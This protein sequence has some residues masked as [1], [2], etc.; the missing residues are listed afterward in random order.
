MTLSTFAWNIVRNSF[1]CWYRLGT[2]SN[3]VIR[4]R[5]RHLPRHGLAGRLEHGAPGLF[6]AAGR[7]REAA[8][9]GS[10]PGWCSS[11]RARWTSAF[12]GESVSVTD[13]LAD[14][15][16]LTGSATLDGLT[17]QGNVGCDQLLRNDVNC[18]DVFTTGVDALGAVSCAALTA[19]G[20][21]AGAT[22]SSTGTVSGSSLSITGAASVGLL[23]SAT[24][25]T[26]N[27]GNFTTVGDVST[28]DIDGFG[29]SNRGELRGHR[30]AHG[31]HA[32]HHRGGLRGPAGLREPGLHLHGHKRRSVDGQRGLRRC[33]KLGHGLRA[34]ALRLQHAHRAPR[35]SRTISS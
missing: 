2:A 20:T 3:L 31:R 6:G 18:T 35:T 12:E 19:A 15:L 13:L 5:H 9:R 11:W 1:G 28:G 8:L 24:G 32:D 4:G 27:A 16:A 23:S 33:D 34:A 14:S 21:V 29:R 10:I 25:I 26:G 7:S 30:S 17:A 22:L